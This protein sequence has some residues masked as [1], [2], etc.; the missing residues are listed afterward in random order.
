MLKFNLKKN[1]S[2]MLFIIIFLIFAFGCNKKTDGYIIE[3]DPKYNVPTEELLIKFPI[4]Y[5]TEAKTDLNKKVQNRI[6]NYFNRINMGYD[7]LEQWDKV[8]YHKDS[9]LNVNGIKMTLKEYQNLQNDAFKKYDIKIGNFTNMI[10]VDDFVAIQYDITTTEKERSITVYG[11]N[12]EF[13]RFGDYE[14]LGVKVNEDFTGSRNDV[15]YGILNF[16]NE[17]EKEKQNM[18]MENIAYSK[19][20][21]TTNL[22]EKYPIQYP[23]TID[24]DKGKKMKNIILE[25]FEAWN[26]GY[27][28]WN[29]F[30]KEYYDDNILYDHKGTKCNKENIHLVMENLIANEKIV[31]INNI[32]ISEDW[33]A[34]HFWNSV[35]MKDGTKDAFNHMQFIHFVEDKNGKLKIDLCFAK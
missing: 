13:M 5:K 10:L 2:K 26:N 4:K 12:M 20:I 35:N 3:L 28:T 19:L 11:T 32:L 24:T 7:G 22:E 16:I 15:Y 23:T 30:I 31:R 27:D 25:Y 18:L 34:V 9:I 14:E 21:D 8:L 33:A 29:D 17:N 1:L 6:L